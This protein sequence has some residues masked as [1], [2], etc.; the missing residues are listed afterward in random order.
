[1]AEEAWAICDKR[2]KEQ[3]NKHRSGKTLAPIGAGGP[4][5]DDFHA[6]E[7]LTGSQKRRG[8]VNRKEWSSMRTQFPAPVSENAKRG[9]GKG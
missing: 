2:T 1:V 3:E 9:E 7:K 4:R 5:V 8:K 6:S